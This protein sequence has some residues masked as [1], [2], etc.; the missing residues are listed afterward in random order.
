M[1]A[2]D[3]E[4]ARATPIPPFKDLAHR[5]AGRSGYP[6]HLVKAMTLRDGTSLTI[7]P[8]C[9]DDYELEAEFIRRLS[10]RS[11]YQRLLS[12]RKLTSRE[13][14]R[15]VNIDYTRELAL[16]ALAVVD[17]QVRQVGVARYAPEHDGL[18]HDFGI[19]V[20]DEWQGR[21]LGEALLCSLVSAA[22]NA[23][24][25]QLTGLTLAENHAMRGLA[26]RL[27]FHIEREPGDATVV[28]LQMALNGEQSGRRRSAQSGP[29][30]VTRAPTVAPTAVAFAFDEE[31]FRIGR[32]D[33]KDSLMS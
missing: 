17:N 12:P 27:G 32:W 7:R 22:A 10:A 31:D 11:G 19:V 24:V 1:N 14:E 15:F 5:C 13:I 23:G 33:N 21:G 30:V 29:V 18:S 6:S 28:Q 26:L 16:I 4:P 8:I 9:S 25:Q 2:I 3:R 20:A